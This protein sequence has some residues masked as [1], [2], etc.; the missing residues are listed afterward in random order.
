MRN[1]LSLTAVTAI[2]ALTLTAC[3]GTPVGTTGPASSGELTAGP[4]FDG[5]TISVGVLN[6]TSGMVAAAAGLPVLAGLKLRVEHINAAGGIA[7][8]YPIKLDIQDTEYNP[9][10]AL[11]AYTG[12]SGRVALIGS[13]LGTGVVQ[14]LLPKLAQD[15]TL[16]VPAS[17]ASDWLP[18]PNLLPTQPTYEVSFINGMSHLVGHKGGKDK[19]Y[20]V[21]RQDDATG[22]ANSK[23]IEFG[24][25][26][27]GIK[28]AKDVVFPA[29]TT[30]FT[31]QVQQL[32]AAKCDVVFYASSAT[33]AQKTIAS[34]IQ[35]DFAPTWMSNVA[36]VP[37]FLVGSPSKNYLAENWL[38]AMAGAQWGDTG[39]P[40]MAQMV[41]DF[42]KY[43]DPQDKPDP[44]LWT[45]GYT[46]GLAVEAL[47]E[48]AVKDGDLSPAHITEL[49]H[50]SDFTIDF[51]GLSPDFTYGPVEDRKSPTAVSVL[52]VDPEIPGFLRTV[53]PN[54]D[55]AAAKAF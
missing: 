23:G 31:A 12:M 34:A 18:Q 36:G 48:R 50:S 39:V 45:A 47:L 16:A 41:D 25:E 53:A 51:Q 40:G 8:K 24:A 15:K 32:K 22:E 20:C 44:S 49:S 2:A 37:L 42:K 55:S 19:N 38:V 10:T 46:N 17:A 7:G 52:A 30:D 29:S 35:L 27:L 28:I 11:R 6:P 13:V 21:Y 3:G 14:A 54:V 1:S 5:K 43:G 4:G 9:Q 33:F 26:K